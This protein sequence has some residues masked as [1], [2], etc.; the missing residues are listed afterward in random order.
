MIRF[1][2][3]WLLFATEFISLSTATFVSH[4]ALDLG[5][6]EQIGIVGSYGGISLYTD[7]RQL[8]QIPASTASVISYSNQTFQL[9]ASSSTNGSIHAACML[10]QDQQLYVGGDFFQLNSVNV[11][12][13]AAMDMNTGTVTAL[14]KGLDGPVYSLYCDA[15][16]GYVYVG[17]SFVA[18]IAPAPEYAESLAYFGGS[19]AVWTGTGWQGLPWKGFDGNVNAITRS[20][21]TS[22]IFFGGLFDTTADGQSYYAPASQPVSL[23]SPSV[24]KLFN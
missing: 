4:P 13:I 22:S 6:L 12:N 19:V 17:G 11:S 3:W 2:W 21:K 23:V 8:T 15:T 14:Q 24:S 9:L 10:P 5:Q 16:S 18:P 20:E 1:V 7:T